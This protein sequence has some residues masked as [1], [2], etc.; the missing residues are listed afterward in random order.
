MMQLRTAYRSEIQAFRS[1]RADPDA[2]L[3][4]Y[5]LERA[6]VLS[7]PV[8]RFH[9]HVHWLMLVF[10]MSRRERREVRGQVLRLMLAPLGTLFGRIPAGNTGRASVSIASPMP[11]PHDLRRVLGEDSGR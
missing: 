6:H 10:A 11:I 2:A 1:F 7:Q 3:A 9:L 5:H 4:W 8:L